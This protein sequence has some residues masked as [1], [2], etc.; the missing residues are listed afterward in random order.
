[1]NGS[2]LIQGLWRATSR[3]LFTALTL[4]A[5]VQAAQAAGDPVVMTREG[6]VQGT[7]ERGVDVFR[8]IPYAAPP[9]GE[10]RW[11]PARPV[12]P[13]TGLRPALDFGP[14]CPQRIVADL[15]EN[16][17]Q[18]Q[19]E[20]CLTLNVWTPDVAGPKRP[21]MVWIHGGALAIGSDRNTWY[22]G[23]RL[24]ARGNLLVV[25]IQ[26]RL[27]LLG[28]LDLSRIGGSEYAQSGNLGI[29]DE[30]AALRWVRKNIAAFGGD[31]DNVTVF[32]ES[33]GGA[34]VAVLLAT[35]LARGLFNKGIIE[36]MSP[37]LGE[38]REPQSESA[39]ALM[40]AAGVHTIKGLR[41]LS[42]GRLFAAERKA[43]AAHRDAGDFTTKIDH[44]LLNANALKLIEE[45]KLAHVPVIIGT[46][47]DEMNFF[48]TIEDFRQREKPRALLSKQLVGAFGRQ[49]AADIEKAYFSDEK[50]SY[51]DE[52]IALN[53]GIF[54]R[55]PSIRLA[56]ASSASQP[57]WM[58]LFTYRSTSTYRPYASSHAM[59]LP[60]VFDN[61]EA[62]DAIA[63]TGR[64]PDRKR[65]S[66]Q[67][68]DAWIAFARAGNPN[69][70]GLPRWPRYDPHSRA[71]MEFGEV[72]HVV[73]D[74]LRERRRV[75]NDLAFNGT[76]PAPK[77]YAPL[78]FANGGGST[79]LASK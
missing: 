58:Y 69:A 70:P 5:I 45:G 31:P 18:V 59:E 44:V 20:N 68:Q 34:S 78:M 6:S 37:Q 71:T 62:Q 51:G 60:F 26:Y 67:I 25:T 39:R 14:A 63:F 36:S 43:V 77:Q 13:W 55:I 11:L 17:D 40:E 19:S 35:P 74:P 53:S 3:S 28:F 50:G 38:P 23:A 56:E 32:G 61:L 76:S 10:L 54:F 47:L 4:V 7:T 1:M 9:V 48:D 8:G 57:T 73:D 79:R 41:G 16:S 49:R 12:R 15:T 29:L 21:V 66:E 75:F 72:T 52:V 33:A 42:V 30:I 27:G 24:A 22:D 2:V 65:L 64:A 46:N